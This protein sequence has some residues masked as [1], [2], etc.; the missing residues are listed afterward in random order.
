TGRDGLIGNED[1]GQMSAWFVFSAMGFYPVMPASGEYI[2]GSPLFNKVNIKLENGKTFSIIAPQNAPE[3]VYVKSIRRG[4]EKINDARLSIK[5][6]QNGS[7]VIMECSAQPGIDPGKKSASVKKGK[8]VGEALHPVFTPYLQNGR[9]C[10][11]NP[12]YITLKCLTHDAQIR[13]TLDGSEPDYNSNIFKDSILINSNTTLKAAT[14]V[15][16]TNNA[17][18]AANRSIDILEQAFYRTIYR[19]TI[20]PVYRSGGMI[21]P[22]LE[23]NTPY[24]LDYAASGPN[25][26]I[27][28]VRGTLRYTDRKWQSH[29]EKQDLDVV[30]DLGRPMAIDSIAIGLLHNSDVWIL[31]PRFVTFSYSD[32][33]ENFKQLNKTEIPE[34][35]GYVIE[36]KD[37]STG[38][39]NIT[40]R[41]L[42][43]FAK[44]HDGLPAWHRSAGS[45]V[46]IFADE[47]LIYPKD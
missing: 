11:Y 4:T 37:V 6:I 12:Q 47:V 15:N 23:H 24:S 38:K 9:T 18:N 34:L 45:N 46:L 27:D 33:G 42:R 40:P 19:D 35:K 39:I 10:F 28:G 13:F 5:D 44:N 20:N 8:T 43:I 21:Y 16:S 17:V 14:F 2:L 41:Y 7:L 26:L 29:D 30:I 1:C 32:D 22:A 3:N 36:R 31:Y 25:A